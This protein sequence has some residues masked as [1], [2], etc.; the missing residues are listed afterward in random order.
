MPKHDVPDPDIVLPVKLVIMDVDGVMTD[1]SVVVCADGSET[2]TFNVKD[3]SGIKYLMR[4]GLRTA[5]LSGRHCPPVHHRAR[6]LGIERC[7]TGHRD[8]L[9]AYRELV[10][11]MG[12]SDAEV[13]Y[14][15]DDLPDIP[16][17]RVAGF[18]V[19]VADAVDEVLAFASYVT[20]ARGGCGAIR[21]VAELILKVQGKWDV[22]MRRYVG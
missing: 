14:V 2:K 10:R 5:I 13:C 6:D 9:P 18:P 3:G 19:A 15:G 21:E 4:S 20:R 17:M 11:E 1:G 16:P 12:L 22:L 7:L 8:K